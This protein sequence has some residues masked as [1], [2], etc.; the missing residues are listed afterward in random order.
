MVKCSILAKKTCFSNK[1]RFTKIR[2]NDRGFTLIELL[3]VIAIVG[4][5]AG[6]IL[7]G[8][9]PAQRMKE[10]RDAV[11]QQDVRSIINMVEQERISKRKVLR[12]ITL[13]GCSDCVCR[14]AGVDVRNPTCFNSM[15][16]AWQRVAGKDMPKDP[17]GN[18]YM[19]DENEGEQPCGTADTLSSVGP[20][21]LYGG[22][23]SLWW[24]IPGYYC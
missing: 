15:N 8:I 12:Y 17:W 22:S 7:I 14:T 6:V 21:H 3:L 23:D 24:S 1:R 10:A 2:F 13:S 20:D 9:N 5:L 18:P 4:I 19:I 16:T 11:L